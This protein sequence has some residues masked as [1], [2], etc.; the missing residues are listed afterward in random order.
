MGEGNPP[1]DSRGRRNRYNLQP[2]LNS[3]LGKE[4][5]K[6]AFTMMSNQ[7]GVHP[8]VGGHFLYEELWHPEESGYDDQSLLQYWQWL[9]TKYKTIDALNTDWGT[10]YKEFEDIVQPTQG[11]NEFWQFTP[12]YVNFRKFRG[13]AQR[14]MIKSAS[15]LTHQKEPDHFNWGAK[16]DFGTQSWYP[17]EFMD[18]FG[19]YS[20][21][22]AASV[23]R[24]FGNT[25]ITSGYHFECEDC[26]V[27]GRKQFDHK[28]GPRRYMGKA[29]GDMYNRLV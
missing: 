6:E 22:V 24:Y 8:G 11:K 16:G 1:V 19:W 20:P 15:Q 13:W 4:I 5:Q 14:E 2:P 10:H 21:L 3:A 7:L 12:E 17:G 18:G 25:A 9:L 26:Y 23:S 27:D 28:P 29:E